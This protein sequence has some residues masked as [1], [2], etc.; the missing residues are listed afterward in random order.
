M[1]GAVAVELRSLC[2]VKLNACGVSYLT[3]ALRI[4][5]RQVKAFSTTLSAEVVAWGAYGRVG[6]N[7]VRGG[8]GVGSGGRAGWRG[9]VGVG[10]GGEGW[11]VMRCDHDRPEHVGEVCVLTSPREDGHLARSV[12]S[13]LRCGPLFE[14]SS[15]LWNESTG[16][17]ESTAYVSWSGTFS[18]SA[19][20]R[21]G[22]VSPPVLC[23]DASMAPREPRARAR[24]R[25]CAVLERAERG[26]GV[27]GGGGPPR[28]RVRGRAAP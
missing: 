21:L 9:G 22:S 27:D 10:V 24:E 15:I 17:A 3:A 2:S 28:N 18:V 4:S 8:E 14:S 1:R 20:D 13:P 11:G 6:E 26:E 25:A 16:I 5:R 7:G 12:P 19:R 23:A